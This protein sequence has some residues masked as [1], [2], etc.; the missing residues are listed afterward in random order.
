MH[1]GI[2]TCI[3]RSL[4]FERAQNEI[5][6]SGK[7]PSTVHNN[8]GESCPRCGDTIREVAYSKYSVNYCA[9]CQTNGKVLA[10]NTTSKF[11]K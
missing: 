8:T 1:A 10:D 3:A 9:T 4:E 11:L 2:I 6:A 7:R 5:V